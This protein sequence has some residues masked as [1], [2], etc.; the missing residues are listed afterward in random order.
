MQTSHAARR[1]AARCRID[2]PLYTR[3]KDGFTANCFRLLKH[4][5]SMGAKQ[6]FAAI[7]VI[8]F[9]FSKQNQCCCEFQV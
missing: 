2:G 4:W 7:A 8:D 5:A 3:L 6:R 1:A 9:A